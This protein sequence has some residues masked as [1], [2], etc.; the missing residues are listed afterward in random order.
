MISETAQSGADFV[1]G[2]I[3]G[4]AGEI[5]QQT[6]NGGGGGSSSGGE[7][8][9][10]FIAALAAPANDALSPDQMIARMSTGPPEVRRA[11]VERL[12]LEGRYSG[13][14]TDSFTPAVIAA[15]K[16]TIGNKQ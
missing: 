16:R 14:L 10:W 2:I 11:I 6:I 4:V 13:P 12:K 7:A 1:K 9:R 3:G 15:M 8:A 5:I